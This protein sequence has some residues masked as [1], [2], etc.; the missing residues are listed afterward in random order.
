[1]QERNDEIG[2]VSYPQAGMEAKPT[3]RLS[4]D[5][6]AEWQASGQSGKR[7]LEIVYDQVVVDLV[8]RYQII[9]SGLT[10]GLRD[11]LDAAVSSHFDDR[12][13]YAS[14]ITAKQAVKSQ[15]S[16]AELGEKLHTEL[17]R[18]Y[19]VP[20]A[21]YQWMR[22]PYR[23]AAKDLTAL[24]KI[25]RSVRT[26]N[27]E[28]QTGRKNNASKRAIQELGDDICWFWLTGWTGRLD[29]TWSLEPP[30]IS[31]SSDYFK[32]AKYIYAFVC[33]DRGDPMIVT[34]LQRAETNLASLESNFFSRYRAAA[35][36]WLEEKARV[37]AERESW[38]YH[39]D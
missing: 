15:R 12:L 27:A 21:G 5:R 22:Q 39:V 32:F 29:H 30:K 18:F 17:R 24:E 36:A 19:E 28:R 31:K 8:C 35:Q 26:S 25:L 11:W 37:A 9:G 38:S 4:A 6:F 3:F 13:A 34:R 7:E 16:I 23:Q 33:E 2:T 14:K 10:H 1:M 20:R